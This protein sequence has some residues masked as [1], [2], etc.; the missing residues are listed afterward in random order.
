MR[1][2]PVL[3][4]VGC[5]AVIIVASYSL[6]VSKTY[7]APPALVDCPAPD[8]VSWEPAIPKAGALFLVRL[9]DTAFVS[10]AVA[11][12]RLHFRESADGS[13]T[14]VGH[15]WTALAAVPIDSTTG[16]TLSYLCRGNA[17]A[18]RRIPTD[19]G[20]Y[21]LERL[22]VAPQFSAAPS[23]ALS[24]RMRD[25]SARAATVSR[26]SHETPILWL[27][28]FVAPRPTRVTSRFGS[29]RTFN[30]TVTGRHMGTDYA[31]AV[32]S[33][34][35]AVNRGVVRLVDRFYLGGNVIYLDH[36]GGLVTAYLHLSKQ[37]VAVGDTVDRGAVI[38]HVGATGRVTGPHLHVIARYGAITV[39]ASRLMS[40]WQ[41]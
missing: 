15:S 29:G 31:G 6:M 8:A 9:S 25:E 5:T 7:G 14:T 20:D 13:K 1:T 41:P 17:E 12:E 26:E 18:P 32:G 34:V 4:T 21:P 38:G 19:S 27:T 33:P 22:S 35:K 36:G 11:G 2:A 3:R 16:V 23:A 28:S 30:G 10:A 40:L 24:A 37:L 39:D